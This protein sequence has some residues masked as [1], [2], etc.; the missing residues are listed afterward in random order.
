MSTDKPVQE[1]LIPEIDE[2]I[3][4]GDFW[5]THSLADDWDETEPA[6]LEFA[7]A[8]GRRMLVSVDPDLLLRVQHTAQI[9]GL[10]TES[11]VNLL[12]EQRMQQLTA[13]TPIAV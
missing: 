4:L 10:S 1:A 13:A 9:W 5:E 2:H 3:A 6:N 11:L 8:L 7:P 12:L